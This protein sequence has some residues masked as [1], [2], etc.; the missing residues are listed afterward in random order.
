M[1]LYITINL[2]FSPYYESHYEEYLQKI[3]Y[4]ELGHYYSYFHDTTMDTFTSICRTNDETPVNVCNP[5][6]FVSSYATSL[7]EEDY[8]ETFAYYMLDG[9]NSGRPILQQK[10]DYFKAKD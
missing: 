3:I 4:H 7:Q 6:D 10:I 9:S 8:A 5:Q 2:C 1:H